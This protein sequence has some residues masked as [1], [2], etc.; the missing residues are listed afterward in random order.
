M[1]KDIIRARITSA[2][3]KLRSKW[4]SIQPKEVLLFAFEALCWC[5][6]LSTIIWASRILNPSTVPTTHSSR[7]IKNNAV[8][9]PQE[10]ATATVL[11]LTTSIAPTPTAILDVF[12]VSI[13]VLGPSGL[14]DTT[15]NASLSETNTIDTNGGIRCEVKLMEFVFNTSFG[16]PFIGDYTPPSCIGNSNMVVM[17]FTVQSKGTQFDRLA[18]MYFGDS[19]V[20]RTSTAEPR[21][22]GITWTYEKDMSEYIFFWKSPQKVIFDLPNQTTANLTGT[23]NTTLTA[24]FFNAPSSLQST[25]ADLILPISLQTGSNSSSA[26]SVF[27][28][29]SATHNAST[30]LTIPRNTN[31]A[32]L[33]LSTT[34]QA[35]EEFWWS[36]VLSSDILAFNST[37][38]PL[39]GS[40]PFREVQVLIDGQLAGVQWP[41]PVIFTGGVV[42]SLWSPVVGI[43][44]FDLKEYEIDIS[45]WLGALCD[46]Q[47]H[48][49]SIR[50][51]G[52]SDDGGT[53]GEIADNVGSNWMVTGKVFI[54]RD[55]NV[56]AVTT[57]AAPTL[58][59]SPPTIQV[60]QTLEKNSTGGNE[61]LGY[62]VSVQRSL[63]ITGSITT[64][65]YGANKETRWSQSMTHTDNGTYLRS[66]FQQLNTITTTGSDTC[67]G[68][69]PYAYTYTYPLL[70]NISA[71][72]SPSDGNTTITGTITRSKNST[73][74]PPNSSVHP[75]GIQAFSSN[76]K[77]S[78]L[79]A[80]LQTF[81]VNTTQSGT[82]F[83]FQSPS[84]GVSTGMGD[85]WTEMR[86]GGVSKSGILGGNTELWYRRVITRNG[87]VIGDG[88]RVIGKGFGN[89]LGM[90]QS[91]LDNLEGEGMYQQVLVSVSE[92]DGSA[93]A[94][95]SLVDYS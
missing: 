14:L 94:K 23:F 25:P 2:V 11:S 29:P 82:A 88:G 65:K 28:L 17:N 43:D 37:G 10:Q 8:R 70:A 35:S 18:I 71:I 77:S 56:N 47:P 90:S 26:P 74:S 48:T 50:V 27:V 40:S 91:E 1:D 41:F 22:N 46:G 67:T 78:Q 32:I 92:G 84:K 53:R 49:F 66:G 13:P 15:G 42:P 30:S 58:S 34:G 59:I 19:E 38:G 69:V 86:V 55:A 62:F 52:L 80:N 21:K 76:P 33:S 87:S 81:N 31:R 57:G 44:A 54:W 83:L 16:K 75:S 5:L 85:S 9:S 3:D 36:N 4:S 24:T 61:T 64:Q 45:P 60:S 6:A 63:S 39:L 89:L 95:G 73:L 20:F 93:L 79:V 68:A 72:V 12:Q 7:D 51:M